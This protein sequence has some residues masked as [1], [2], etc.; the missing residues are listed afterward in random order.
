MAETRNR[1]SLTLLVAALVGVATVTMVVDRRALR[2]STRE[3]PAWAGGLLDAAA[4]QYVS[5]AVGPMVASLTR[6]AS[7]ARVADFR[8]STHLAGDHK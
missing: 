7:A 3:L 4:G 6:Y 5:Q 1:V 2:D 8:L